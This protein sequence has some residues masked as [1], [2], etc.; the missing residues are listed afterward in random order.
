MERKSKMKKYTKQFIVVLCVAAVL[1]ALSA[2]LRNAG[3]IGGLGRTLKNWG[4]DLPEGY[5]VEYRAATDTNMDEG[6]L[7]FHVLLYED[8]A[9]LDS[10]VSWAEIAGL[11]TGY[12]TF[13]ADEITAIL[14]ELNV[15]GGER[16]DLQSG[17]VWQCETVKDGFEEEIF[18]L[19]TAGDLRLY[20]VES[21]RNP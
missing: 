19:H 8:G 13:A 4:V 10:M 5:V 17:H 1:L 11:Q 6:G 9:A 21:F 12:G 16:P 18:L 20:L 15:P 14:D 7:R 3:G 2:V